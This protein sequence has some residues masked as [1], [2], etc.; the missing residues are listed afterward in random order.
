MPHCLHATRL[1]AHPIPP[2][3]LMLHWSAM[4]L[5]LDPVMW[6]SHS[7]FPLFSHACGCAHPPCPVRFACFV[8]SVAVG[9]CCHHHRHHHHHHHHHAG[10]RYPLLMRTLHSWLLAPLHEWVEI[11]CVYIKEDHV[12]AEKDNQCSDRPTLP[13]GSTSIPPPVNPPPSHTSTYGWPAPCRHRWCRIPR[14]T[15]TPPPLPTIPLFFHTFAIPIPPPLLLIHTD[16]SPRYPS[17]SGNLQQTQTAFT[18]YPHT[19]PSSTAQ[20]YTRAEIGQSG[21]KMINGGMP[22]RGAGLL[23]HS[24][25]SSGGGWFSIVFWWWCGRACL[26]VRVCG[27]CCVFLCLTYIDTLDTRCG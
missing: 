16:E 17:R 21:G 5:L 20:I 19:H 26:P 11:M 6:F 18:I 9:C 15:A 13:P 10:H 12:S 7:A 4:N 14:C 27:V 23:C 25:S 3:L 8:W 1:A 24:C 22:T 2:P